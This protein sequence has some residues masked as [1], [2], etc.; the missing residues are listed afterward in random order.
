LVDNLYELTRGDQKLQLGMDVSVHWVENG[1]Y[2]RGKGVV[3]KLEKFSVM[4]RLY[5]AEGTVQKSDV[6]RLL[7]LPR[8]ADQTRWSWR[9]CV[10][11]AR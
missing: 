9:N 8:F 7:S 6:K 4:V 10:L 3:A 11:P 1:F 2:R 5:A